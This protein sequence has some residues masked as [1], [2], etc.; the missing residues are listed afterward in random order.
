MEVRAHSYLNP[1]GRCD[2]CQEDNNPDPGCCD[3]ST[4]RPRDETCPVRC[5]TTMNICLRS[6]GSTV[7]LT[8][9]T[10]PTSNINGTGLFLNTNSL[11]FSINPFFEIANPLMLTFASD[12]MVSR[13]L[14]LSLLLLTGSN[15]SDFAILF[16]FRVLILAILDFNHKT[17]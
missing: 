4:I 3:E 1:T 12:V 15:F 5:D 6:V 13:S 9:V 8:G 16:T 10:C 11:D 7:E 2:E 17:H 14:T